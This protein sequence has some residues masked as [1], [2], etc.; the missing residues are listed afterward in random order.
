MHGTHAG[1]LLWASQSGPTDTAHDRAASIAVPIVGT[2]I[3]KRHPPTAP[4]P[5]KRNRP[6]DKR[7][8]GP[9]PIRSTSFTPRMFPDEDDV[10]FVTA[11]SISVSNG[12]ATALAAFGRGVRIQCMHI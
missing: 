9:K 11:S 10:Y 3:T 2:A 4:R 7:G 8:L 1:F 5:H 12:S 6:P